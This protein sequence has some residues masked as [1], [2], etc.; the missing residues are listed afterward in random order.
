MANSPLLSP[1]LEQ[2]GTTDFNHISGSERMITDNNK[3]SKL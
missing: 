1:L 2:V 3:L